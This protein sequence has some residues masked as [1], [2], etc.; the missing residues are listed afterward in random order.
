MRNIQHK[1][2]NEGKEHKV[3]LLF[4]SLKKN[5]LSPIKGFFSLIMVMF[6][7]AAES[8]LSASV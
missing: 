5:N 7:S 6:V 2:Y 1:K 3:F 4:V 8:I